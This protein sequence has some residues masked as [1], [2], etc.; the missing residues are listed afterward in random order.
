MLINVQ[1][2]DFSKITLL[3]VAIHVIQVVE[4]VSILQSLRVFPV[5]EINN[6]MRILALMIVHHLFKMMLLGVLKTVMMIHYL[7][8]V[9]VLNVEVTILMI[10]LIV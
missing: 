8:I 5:Q 7:V 9:I 2:L 4:L 1:N 10:A 3:K 6:Y